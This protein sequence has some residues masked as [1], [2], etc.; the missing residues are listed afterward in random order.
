M[1]SKVQLSKFSLILSIAV[2][3]ILA[4][5]CVST[6]ATG[7]FIIILAVTLLLLISAMIYAPLAISADE[8][9]LRIHSPLKIH[10]I[11]MRRIVSVELHAPTMGARRIFGSG[12]FMGYWGIFSE[13]DTGRYV[14]HHGKSSDCFLIRLDN[15]DKYL[16]G[17]QHP[18]TMIA[19]IKAH[20]PQ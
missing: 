4:V 7:K 12:G 19:H 3:A 20:L 6:Y 17:C 10:T 18:D 16:L 2:M 9:Q 8:K 11:P 15:G 5:G 1:K 13:A 14:A